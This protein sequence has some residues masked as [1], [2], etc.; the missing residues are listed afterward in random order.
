[1][2]IINDYS[3]SIYAAQHQREL[4]AEAQS[5]RLAREA[6]DGRPGVLGHLLTGLSRGSYRP[7]HAAV[8]VHHHAA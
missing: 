1:M 4:V 8:A 6:R 7:G 2:S 3:I 5:N